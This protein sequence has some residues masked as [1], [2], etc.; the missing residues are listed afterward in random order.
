MNSTPRLFSE[1][2]HAARGGG[3]RLAHDAEFRGEHDGIAPA[4]Q[5]LAHGDFVGMAPVHIGRVQKRN[6]ERER[7]MN[8]RNALSFRGGA[9]GIKSGQAHATQPQRGNLQT[10][11]TQLTCFHST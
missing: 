7:A 1:A 5:R 2:S 11:R 10:L 3:T 9:A 6:A 4:L 8:Q